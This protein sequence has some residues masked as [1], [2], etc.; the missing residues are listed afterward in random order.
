MPFIEIIYLSAFTNSS[1]V[2]E[3]RS[4]DPLNYLVKPWTEEQ[5]KVTIQM[6]FNFI[7]EK[8]KQ[9]SVLKGLSLSEY[10]II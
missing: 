7:E 8:E 1:I 2:E 9:N 4:T 5:I 10:K 6:A 3:A